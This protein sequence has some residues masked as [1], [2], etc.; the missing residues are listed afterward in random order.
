MTGT[1]VQQLEVYGPD[2]CAALAVD[3][4]RRWC[5]RLAGRRYENF[6]VLSGLVPRS[7]RDDYAAL[8]AFCRWAD[9]LGDEV[10]DPARSQELLGWW[11]RELG[12]CFAGNPRHPV[13]VALRPAIERHELPPEPFDDLIAAFEQDQTVRRYETWEQLLGYCRRS[14]DPV[15]RLVLMIAGEPRTEEL[16]GLSDAMCTALQLTNHWQ[17][18]R[19]DILKRDRIY[20]PRELIAIP[21]FEERLVVAARQGFA[22]DHRFL[23]ESRRIIRV[24]VDRT[25]PLFEN[26]AGLLGKLRP[27]TRSFV[28]L[29]L[30]GGQRVLRLIELWNYETALHRPRLSKARKSMLIGRAWLRAR[31]PGRAGSLRS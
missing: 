20:I 2:R 23:E 28:E 30:A 18:V 25:W 27:R 17:D 19:R 7:L 16:F 1:V 4:A 11:R 12:Q 15:G 22:P 3:D 9:D 14:A 13:F 10:G 31:L 6:S 29:F 21:D 5:R 24:C 26:G 8:Y